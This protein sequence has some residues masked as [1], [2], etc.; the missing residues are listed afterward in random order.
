MDAPEDVHAAAG[1]LASVELWRREQLEQA[2]YDEHSA[3]LVAERADVD[4]HAACEL[5]RRGCPVARAVRIL[6]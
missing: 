6:L 2:G 1:E 3:Q 4:L 5:V